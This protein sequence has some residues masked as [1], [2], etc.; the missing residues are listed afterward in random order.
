MRSLLSG[1]QAQALEDGSAEMG[2]DWWAN[3]VTKPGQRGATRFLQ[4]G[5]AAVL[6]ALLILM[7][8]MRAT[9]GMCD[10]I[11]GGVIAVYVSIVAF[12]FVD[13]LVVLLCS[14]C[15]SCY[16]FFVACSCS[17]VSSHG[18][19]MQHARSH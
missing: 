13:V 6:G 18:V 15:S 7:F 12:D 17:I 1:R 16:G 8:D 14:Y 2:H 10:T 3:C 4:S 19:A 11:A 5:P 9:I